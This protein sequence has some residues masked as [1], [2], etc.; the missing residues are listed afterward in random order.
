MNRKT[1]QKKEKRKHMKT[2]ISET[3]WDK[4]HCCASLLINSIE[5][6]SQSFSKL[7][8]KIQVVERVLNSLEE[9]Y[10]QHPAICALRGDYFSH[11]AM[12]QTVD[13]NV[14]H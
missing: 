6:G 7:N 14:I 10:G 9:K 5:D 3:D 8:S 1:V 12:G 2:N 13:R 11:A 4:L